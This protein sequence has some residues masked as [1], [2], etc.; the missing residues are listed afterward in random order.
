M[1][2][3]ILDSLHD[4]LWVEVT[5]R[6][7]LPALDV[8]GPGYAPSEG[9][10]SGTMAWPAACAAMLA[11]PG[12]D[13]DF[14]R[15]AA[16]RD[17]VETLGPVDGAYHA[18][19]IK[20]AAPGLLDD[21]RVLAAAAW[22]NPVRWP[23]VLLG[24]GGWFS[25]TTLRYLSHALWLKSRGFLANNAVVVEI[26]V[27]YGGLAVMNEIVS[28]ACTLLVDLPVVVDVARNVI[29][30]LGHAA[31]LA[32]NHEGRPVCV[33]SNYAFS[34]LN[35]ELQDEYMEK[36]L[37]G[38]A[39]GMILSNAGVFAGAIGGRSDEELVA[40]LRARGIA[41]EI[42]AQDEVLGPSDYLAGV[43]LIAW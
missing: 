11:H 6:M 15:R 2:R 41:A 20:N 27:G 40:C 7:G 22:G 30:R 9:S 16:V 28:K 23:G 37:V 33:V 5:R 32:E 19:L 13:I 21:P 42:H 35:R 10:I 24:T 43:K 18:R 39:H 25:P 36:Y 3:R 34:E 31:A 1:K 14:R 38:S 12:G 8:A 29:R 4:R 26:G 17:V